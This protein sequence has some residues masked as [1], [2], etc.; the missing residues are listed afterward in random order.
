MPI[1]INEYFLG[2]IKLNNNIM[3]CDTFINLLSWLLVHMWNM[4]SVPLDFQRRQCY[5]L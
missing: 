4:Y 5:V 1:I 3:V 2:Y